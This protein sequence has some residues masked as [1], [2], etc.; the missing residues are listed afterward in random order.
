MMRIVKVILLLAL[1]T[2]LFCIAS[3]DR[4]ADSGV[5][6]D[7]QT[8]ASE[9]LSLSEKRKITYAVCR[10]GGGTLSGWRSQHGLPGETA[11]MEVTA[12]PKLGYIFTGWSDGSTEP[13]RKDVFGTEDITFTANFS[14]ERQ[15]LPIISITTATGKDVESKDEYIGAVVS[16]CNTGC[17][18]YELSGVT[19]ELRGRGNGTWTYPKKSYRIRFERK[20]NLMGL[21]KDEHRS[22]IL[23]ANHADRSM[24]RNYLSMYMANLLEGIDYNNNSTHVALYLNG[25]YHGVYLL[26]EQIEDDAARIDI[27]REALADPEAED[28]GFLV[29]LDEYAEDPHRFYVDEQPFEIKSA[30]V[31]EKQRRYIVN[32]ITDVHNAIMDGDRDTLAALIDL[33]SFIDGY[34]L[35]EFFKNIDAGWSSFYMYKKP[36]EKMIIGPFWDFDLSSGNNISLDGGGSTGIYVGKKSGLSQEHVWY[37]HITRETWFTDAVKERW[38]EIQP[39]I[40]ATLEELLRV[41][42]ATPEAFARNYD[43][44]ALQDETLWHITEPQKPFT[45]W[46]EHVDYLHTWL[47]ERR[48]WL[49]EYFESPRAYQFAK[50]E[51][52]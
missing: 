50:R 8:A 24:M 52:R 11:K 41:A 35:E 23:M 14:F 48:D 4:A 44:W 37:I 47:S 12:T 46:R 5:S 27:G 10:T 19:A 49:T 13:T 25:E 45:T 36:G 18:D 33:D 38:K 20:Q 15:G 1:C 39:V 22:W 34:L 3:C 6:S 31:N 21:G 32:Y 42:D 40:D 26:A 30:Y 17:A 16:M 2:L 28:A 43:V 7:T 29:E 51:R 9:E